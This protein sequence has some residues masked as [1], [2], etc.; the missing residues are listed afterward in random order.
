MYKYMDIILM[1]HKVLLQSLTAIMK[2]KLD[3]AI[4]TNIQQDIQAELNIC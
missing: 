2:L 4:C 3:K 1:Y